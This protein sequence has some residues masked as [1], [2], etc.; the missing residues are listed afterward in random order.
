MFM[1]EVALFSPHLVPFADKSSHF[2]LRRYMAKTILTDVHHS[3]LN[4]SREENL[5]FQMYLQLVPL[6]PLLWCEL[7]LLTS[8]HFYCT[9]WIFHS[10]VSYEF[11]NIHSIILGCRVIWGW[12]HWRQAVCWYPRKE[13][14]MWKGCS[15]KGWT[16]KLFQ[17]KT[18]W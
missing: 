3:F 15:L 5:G 14:M 1:N 16:D 11:K 18:S 7:Q 8:D 6:L 9:F 13:G 17:S 4:K 12:E 2:F 10:N